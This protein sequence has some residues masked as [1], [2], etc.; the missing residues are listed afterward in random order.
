MR[1]SRLMILHKKIK[2]SFVFRS[3]HTIKFQAKH[4]LKDLNFS[5]NN[6]SPNNNRKRNEKKEWKRMEKIDGKLKMV[7]EDGLLSY[8]FHPQLFLSSFL[9]VI[10]VLWTVFLSPHHPTSVRHN[11]HKGTR[12]L[13][14]KFTINRR[15]RQKQTGKIHEKKIKFARSFKSHQRR[16]R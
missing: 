6:K 14:N 15:K 16:L 4:V 8:S 1:K 12:R 9:R 13:R 2:E 7:N 10:D 11:F 5:D 3:A